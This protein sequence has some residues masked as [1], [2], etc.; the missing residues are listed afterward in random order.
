MVEKIQMNVNEVLELEYLIEQISDG[1]IQ[2]NEPTSGSSSINYISKNIGVFDPS[3]T[4]IHELNINGQIIEV[5]VIE[6]PSSAVARYNFEENLTDLWNDNAGSEVSA[7]SYSRTSEIGDYA[8]ES[9]G[10]STKADLGDFWNTTQFS[11]AGW[12]YVH[13][14][15]KKPRILVDEKII[16]GISGN[17][18]G[19]NISFRVSGSSGSNRITA[20]TPNTDQWYHVVCTYD[21][22]EQRLYVDNDLKNSAVV[23]ITPSNDNTNIT[24]FGT[25]GESVYDGLLD[26]LR[27]YNE[28]LTETDIS[29]LY[30]NGSING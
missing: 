24:L 11:L 2:V 19:N 9:N 17:F 15:T 22:N 26:D 29:N 28:A 3:E 21:G 18:E 1:P 8:I 16:F 12:I 20:F 25:G 30:N 6:I 5:D 13:N 10:S 27:L 14:V 23:G 7:V 4:G